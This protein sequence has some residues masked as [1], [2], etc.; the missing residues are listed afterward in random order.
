MLVFTVTLGVYFDNGLFGNARRQ[1]YRL[2]ARP[3]GWCIQ[4]YFTHSKRTACSACVSRR[5]GWLV[6]NLLPLLQ[7]LLLLL[8]LIFVM[9]EW[10][11]QIDKLTSLRPCN[12]KCQRAYL[13][14]KAERL[15]ADIE[16]LHSDVA[17]K[18]EMYL[19]M[20]W[21]V[22]RWGEWTARG[23]GGWLWLFVS[24]EPAY[25]TATI[26]Q[27]K[28][29]ECQMAKTGSGDIKWVNRLQAGNGM[30]RNETQRQTW[31]E[32]HQQ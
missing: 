12:H 9:L 15:T 29:N 11:Q 28:C 3:S 1:S 2:E 10:P 8:L 4:K 6:E 31:S 7:L 32:K 5:S 21:I 23:E 16:R 13:A 30:K 25:P 17:H 22:Q 27:S 24:P 18:S 20:D 19:C 26:S 14:P